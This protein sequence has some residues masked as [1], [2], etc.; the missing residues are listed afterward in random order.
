MN[1]TT[2]KEEPVFWDATHPT[3]DAHGGRRGRLA[4]GR[5]SP[6]PSPT[7]LRLFTAGRGKAIALS[8]KARAA[9][10]LAGRLGQAFWFNEQVAAWSPG[11]RT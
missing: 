2:G 1:R 6:R 11:P 8:G 5:C 3:L 4:G 9:I 7:T 10:A